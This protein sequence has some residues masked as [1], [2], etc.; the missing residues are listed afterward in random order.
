MIEIYQHTPFTI[1]NS[2]LNWT[3]ITTT[4]YYKNRVIDFEICFSW[5]ACTTM[6]L[7]FE[8]CHNSCFSEI[9]NARQRWPNLI[10]GDKDKV[11]ANLCRQLWWLPCRR[12]LQHK[13]LIGEVDLQRGRCARLPPCCCWRCQCTWCWCGTRSD[14]AYSPQRWHTV[15]R[16]QPPIIARSSA[17]PL[18]S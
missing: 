14:D 10:A 6:V 18:L 7:L 11:I 3:L 2:F 16:V 13:L 4:N 8:K 12:E 1:V 5:D 9:Q 17:H 15:G